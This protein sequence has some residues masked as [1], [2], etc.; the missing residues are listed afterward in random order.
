MKNNKLP[1]YQIQEKTPEKE[2]VLTADKALLKKI[3]FE[4][5]KLEEERR[6]WEN[7]VSKIHPCR[8]GFQPSFRA[9]YQWR[10]QPALMV[11]K[12]ALIL[13]KSRILRA[14]SLLRSRAGLMLV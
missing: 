1:K 13:A 8:I 4:R 14:V 2:E 10:K 11:H 9:I 3:K 6:E 12:T 5:Q 7:I